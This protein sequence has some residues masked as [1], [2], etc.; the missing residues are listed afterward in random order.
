MRPPRTP[1]APP[2]HRTHGTHRT[3]RT[4][5]VSRV[6]RTSRTAG[7]PRTRTGRP[8]RISSCRFSP[9]ARRVCSRRTDTPGAGGAHARARLPAAGPPDP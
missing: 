8:P 6:S 5:R 7:T 2:T 1:S 9:R 4:H 3:R